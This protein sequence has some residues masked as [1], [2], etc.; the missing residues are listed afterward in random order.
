MTP[1]PQRYTKYIKLLLYLLVVVLINLAGL[2][3]FRIRIDLTQNDEYTLSDVSKKVVAT[4]SEPLTVKVFFTK[5]LPPPHNNT[6]RYLQDLLNE[7]ALNNK[8]YFKP[9]YYNVNPVTETISDDARDNREMARSYGIPPVQIQIVD[10]DEIKF[11]QAFMGLVLIHGDIIERIPTITSTDGLEYQLT[12]AIQ[13]LNHKVSALLNLEEKIQVELVLSSS[14]FNVAPYMGIKGLNTYPDRIKKIVEE[15]NTKT[16]DQLTFHH[17][18]PSVIPDA[19]EGDKN[20]ELLPLKWPDIPQ[21]GVTAGKGIIGLLLKYKDQVRSIPLLQVF[22]L[23]IFGTQYQL[24]EVETI[25]EAIETNL[26]RLV[27]INEDIGY[28]S[29]FGALSPMGPSPMGPQDGETISSF[30]ATLDK[31]YTLHPVKLN[32]GPVPA[33]LPC[34]IIPRPTEKL[35]DYAL[36]QIDQALMNGTNLAIFLDAFKETRPAGRQPFMG[37]P[38]PNYVPLDTGLEEMLAH[39][40]VRIKT[41]IVLDENCHRQRV[42]QNRGGGAQDLYFAPIIQSENINHNLA[43]LKSIKSLTTYKISPLELDAARIDAQQLKAHQLLASSK[44]SWEMRDRITL[45]PLFLRPPASDK[46]MASLPLAYLLEGSFSSYFEGKPMPEKPKAKN[47]DADAPDDKPL[48]TE[49]TAPVDLAQIS[50]KNVF[51]AKSP[52]AKIFVMASSEMI[53]NQ[54]MELTDQANQRANA[55]FILDMIDALNNREAIAAM[56]SKAQQYNP[57]EP[58]GAATKVLIKAA[59]MVGLPFLTILCGLLVWYRRRARQKQIK[60]RFQGDAS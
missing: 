53:K 10:N 47:A 58:T 25:K 7:Y 44:R 33:G 46:E 59:N 9:Q 32:E 40:G 28:L 4:L 20:Q 60:L 27:N 2:T 50:G 1:T 51:K 3:L 17:L 38:M 11:K 15:L 36:Y 55:I 29:G 22:K 26:D 41:S 52:A 14:I 18:D 5:D 12:T 57:L 24:A 56:R 49:N 54:L 34:L 48:A 43:Y 35:S 6:Q 21:A 30:K 19:A 16:Y 42:P 45:N 31:T 8:K 39:Y 23:P 37:N 13:K